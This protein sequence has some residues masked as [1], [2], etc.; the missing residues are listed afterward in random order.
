MSISQGYLED[1]AEG[2]NLAAVY[3]LRR[4]QLSSPGETVRKLRVNNGEECEN[5]RG[6]IR[7]LARLSSTA[8]DIPIRL[9]A[10]RMYRARDSICVSATNHHWPE[11]RE[12]RSHFSF[13][14]GSSVANY[15]LGAI[16]ETKH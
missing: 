10:D 5:N 11:A 13:T 7:G 1:D 8:A 15:V 3:V 12:A 6:S 2:R 9:L 4:G 14:D 16:F